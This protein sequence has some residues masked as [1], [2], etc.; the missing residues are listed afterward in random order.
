MSICVSAPF[1]AE[2]F[3]VTEQTEFMHLSSLFPCNKMFMYTFSTFQAMCYVKLV[4]TIK[5]SHTIT[6]FSL[7]CAVMSCYHVFLNWS[8]I[9]MARV[10]STD[11]HPPLR[12]TLIL[13]LSPLISSHILILSSALFFPNPFCPSLSHGFLPLHHRLAAFSPFSPQPDG[14]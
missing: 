8:V 9:L 5:K 14:S 12:V 13:S 7:Q 6:W 2:P 1:L 10:L 11:P 4:S 3:T